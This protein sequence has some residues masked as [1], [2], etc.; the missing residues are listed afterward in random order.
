MTRLVVRRLLFSIPLVLIVSALTFVLAA[1]V[2]GNAARAILGG[3]ATPQ[4]YQA[5]RVQLGLNKP[6]WLQYADWLSGAVRGDLGTSI[7]TGDPVAQELNTRLTVTISLVIGAAILCAAL[8]IL[9]GVT[10]AVRGG[11]FSKV[12]DVLSLGGLALPSFWVGMVLISLFAIH[13]HA[14]PATGYTNFSTSPSMWLAGLVLPVVALSL[15]GITLVAKQTRE[16]MLDS[17]NRDFIRSLR[18]SGVSRRSIIWKHALRTASL[19]VVS[20]LG[21]TLIGVLSGSVFVEAVFVLPGLGSLAVQATENHDLPVLEGIALYF[22]VITVVINL[23]AD[24]AYGWLNPKVR[25]I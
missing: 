2:P 5:M 11:W 24:L 4:E 17:L 18:A 13:M 8:G 25:A 19:P 3:S 20:I 16:A 14:F 15:G 1:I 6:L 23:A 10:S 7:F 9:L 12:I 21:T 22:T